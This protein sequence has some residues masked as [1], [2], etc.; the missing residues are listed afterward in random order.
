MLTSTVFIIGARGGWAS[1]AEFSKNN[2]IERY[3]KVREFFTTNH[4]QQKT[5]LL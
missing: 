5:N 4:Y 2:D 1:C 3:E